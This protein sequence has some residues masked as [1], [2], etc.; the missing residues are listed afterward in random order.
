MIYKDYKSIL[1]LCLFVGMI[2]FGVW[3][4]DNTSNY[5]LS[6]IMFI[7]GVVLVVVFAVI[8]G[9]S[10]MSLYIDNDLGKHINKRKN[11]FCNNCEAKTMQVRKVELNKVVLTPSKQCTI[12]SKCTGCGSKKK[13][14]IYF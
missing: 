2:V 6:N 11:N 3:L 9:V 13:E 12:H 8:M 14:I 1:W 5:V 4:G 7:S 10:L